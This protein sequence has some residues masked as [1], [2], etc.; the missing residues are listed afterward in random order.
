M[1]LGACGP[2]RVSLGQLADHQ[3][4]YAGHSVTVSGTVRHFTDSGGYDVLEDPQ[5]HRVMLR[6][7][8]AV[9]GRV[10]S[11]ITVTGRFTVDPALG[12]VIDVA[13]VSASAP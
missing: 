1:L 9:A 12:R 2:A 11:V 4:Q 8:S 13:S 7:E 3:E 5:Q 6:P 10:G